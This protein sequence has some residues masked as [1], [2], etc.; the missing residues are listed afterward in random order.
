M[1]V[2]RSVGRSVGQPVGGPPPKPH[3]SWMPSRRSWFL[4][5]FAK[6]VIRIRF[7]TRVY[8]NLQGRLPPKKD[9]QIHMYLKFGRGGFPPPLVLRQYPTSLSSSFKRL[10]VF[11]INYITT[12]KCQELWPRPLWSWL[13]CCLRSI[14]H[15]Q[16]AG[17]SKWWALCFVLVGWIY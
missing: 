17:H 2:D 8:I 7:C 16:A 4:C 5:N 6:K 11:L 9:P 10:N 1:S 3:I 15:T 12:L 13:A 14:Q